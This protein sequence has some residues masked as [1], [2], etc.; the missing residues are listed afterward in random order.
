M[1]GAAGVGIAAGTAALAGRA[2]GS[3]GTGTGV[4]LGSA[5]LA[6]AS[7]SILAAGGLTGTTGVS[8]AFVVGFGAVGEVGLGVLADL[9]AG[10][11]DLTAAAR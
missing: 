7:A 9:L 6:E 3:I 4:T 10:S 1:R 8:T 11:F 2:A 5:T